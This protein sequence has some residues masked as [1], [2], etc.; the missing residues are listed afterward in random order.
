MEIVSGIPIKSKITYFIAV[1][2]LLITSCGYYSNQIYVDEAKKAIISCDGNPIR[3]VMIEGP[4]DNVR[5]EGADAIYFNRKN[6]AS[7]ITIA[8]DVN[9][10]Y[11]LKLKPNSSY[12]IKSY[13]SNG[14]QGPYRIILKT[15]NKGNIIHDNENN[16]P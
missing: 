11:I 15:D 8:G 6:N 5:Y 14:D 7:R 4:D 9:N 10:N 12:D 16:C 1:L 3:E 13:S 2:S